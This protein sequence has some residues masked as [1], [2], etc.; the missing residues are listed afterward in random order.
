MTPSLQTMPVGGVC[1]RPKRGLILVVTLRWVEWEEGEGADCCAR[2]WGF[3]VCH[4]AYR[5]SAVVFFSS[6][7][8]SAV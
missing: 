8:G 6:T 2:A 4:G 7:L 3:R 5:P 1:R